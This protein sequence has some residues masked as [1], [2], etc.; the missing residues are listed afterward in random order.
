VCA[1][2][3]FGIQSRALAMRGGD[4]YRLISQSLTRRMH[5]QTAAVFA[6]NSRLDS[7][8]FYSGWWQMARHSE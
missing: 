6:G 7:S 4:E 8:R 1:S 2:L 5:V 3:S